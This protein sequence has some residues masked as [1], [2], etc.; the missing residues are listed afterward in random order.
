MDEFLEEFEW[1]YKGL[2]TRFLADRQFEWIPSNWLNYFESLPFDSVKELNNAPSDLKKFIEKAKNL[3]IL[4][5]YSSINISKENEILHSTTYGKNIKSKKLSEI[6]NMA[7]LISK[8]CKEY[9]ITRIVDVGCGVGYLLRSILLFCPNIKCVGVECDEILC[10]KAKEKCI[11][12]DIIK[13]K[14]NSSCDQN[15]IR[16]IFSLS[17]HTTAII[18]LHGCGDLQR[19]IIDLFLSLDRKTNPLLVTVG[20]CYHKIKNYNENL[21]KHVKW[22]VT[23][24][25]LACQERISKFML[26]SNEDHEK[27]IRNFLDRAKLECL[28]DFIDVK[29][30]N[31]PRNVARKI[32]FNEIKNFYDINNIFNINYNMN[33]HKKDIFYDK[34]EE[35]NKLAEKS[36]CFIEPFTMLQYY[37]QAVLETHILSS[38]IDYIK[39]KTKNINVSLIPISDSILSPRNMAIV[40]M[41]E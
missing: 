34:L 19:T 22:S 28:Y 32:K 35:I 1:L 24:L 25:R 11:D 39:S 26:L 20:C 9:N 41:K 23:S 30:E 3:S 40:A 4:K 2:N 18:S 37:M 33:T 31:I 16:D 8:Y 13:M 21:T 14:L 7:D 15:L 29:R 38:R 17:N 36:K 12:I 27:H 5:D 6:L 10:Q